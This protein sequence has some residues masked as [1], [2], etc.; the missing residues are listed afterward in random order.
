[1]SILLKSFGVILAA[2]VL[3]VVLKQK[4]GEFS[5]LLSLIAV[6]TVGI[7][8]LV[9]VWD[10]V[11][12]IR[13]RLNGYDI[14]VSYFK[15]SLKALFVAYMSETVADTCRDFGQSAMAHK[16]ELAGKCVIFI[17]TVP[18]FCDLLSIA[19]SFLEI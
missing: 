6:I 4:S 17:L 14:D 15:V 9:S 1:M 11:E 16:A 3:S 18:L 8:C 12:K 10:S 7:Y 13:D 2:A 5:F 19:L